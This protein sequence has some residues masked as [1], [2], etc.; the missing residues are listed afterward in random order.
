M[1]FLKLKRAFDDHKAAANLVVKAVAYDDHISSQDEL[2]DYR[3]RTDYTDDLDVI[4]GGIL[5]TI[6]DVDKWFHFPR[7][8]YL[9]KLER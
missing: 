8:L 4:S 2:V 3:V 9:W 6:P 5:M 1:K 7:Y